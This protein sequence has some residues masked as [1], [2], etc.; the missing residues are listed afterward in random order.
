MRS[1]SY[2]VNNIAFFYIVYSRKRRLHKGLK[3]LVAA[4]AAE[5]FREF[6]FP[7]KGFFACNGW[8]VNQRV[9]AL[10]FSVQCCKLAVLFGGVKPQAQFCNFHT[11]FIYIYAVK[12]VFKNRIFYFCKVQFSG[13]NV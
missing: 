11:F 4:V 7:L 12:V 8:V 9:S 10:Y 3:S 5:H 2:M 6:F 13:M 1:S